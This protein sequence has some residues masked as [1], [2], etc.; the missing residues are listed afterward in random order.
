[1]S[2][3]KELARSFC[4]FLLSLTFISQICAST[5]SVD[6]KIIRLE[7]CCG[8]EI[9]PY[10]KEIAKLCNTVYREYPYLY[11]GNDEGYQ[12]YLESYAHSEHSIVCLAFD[13]EKIV[14][15]AT[16]MPMTETRETYQQPFLNHNEK[17]ETFF[18]LGELVLL[19]F[20][21][22]YGIG[23]AMFREVEKL[24][25][26]NNHLTKICLCQIEDVKNSDLKPEGYMPNDHLWSKLGFQRRAELNFS[27]FW[28]N[29]NEREETFHL[30]VFW[31][32]DLD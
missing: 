6:L 20:Y 18:Y 32:K 30:M 26:K 28:T 16:G 11:D 14:G 4:I 5:P 17:M 31:I 12:C 23:K 21:R 22:G 25:R 13:E 27:G 15:V 3:T 7:V 10:A 19:P 24:V 29:V 9:L 8:A 1:M 2:M